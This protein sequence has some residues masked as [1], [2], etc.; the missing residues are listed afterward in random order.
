MY[1]VVKRDGSVVEFS[2]KKI[3]AAVQKAFDACQRDYTP[4]VIDML[5]L[6][7][8]ADFEPKIVDH[9]IFQIAAHLRCQR[10]PPLFVLS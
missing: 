9:K 3:A 2:L 8:T 4:D 1:Q 7:V 5:S 10:I 6:R